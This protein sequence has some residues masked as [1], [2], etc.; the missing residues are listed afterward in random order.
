MSKRIESRFGAYSTAQEVAAGHDLQGKRAI[1]TGGASGI[2]LETVRALAQKGCEVII[3]VRNPAQ[4]DEA[5]ADIAKTSSGPKPVVELI[6]LANLTSVRKFA[7]RNGKKPLH[8]LIN[9][10]GVMACPLSYTKDDLEMQIGTNHFGHYVL[11]ILMSPALMDGAQAQGRA[12]RIVSLSSLAHRR[13]RVNF[14]DPHYRKRPYDKWESYGQSKTANVLFAVAYHQHFGDKGVSANAVMPGG[15]MTALQRYIPEEERIALGW[16]DAQGNQA[17]GF[18]TTEQ[19]ASTS[20]WAA[21]GSELEGIGGL[22]L[23]DCAQALPAEEAPKFKGVR[24]CALDVN[25]ADRLWHLSKSTTG[26]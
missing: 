15:I 19:G 7:E 8:L 14:D 23:E 6:D 21:L 26:V 25:D 10:A 11:S 18:K 4:G 16:I 12:T 17:T 3:A 20:V 5:V 13:S 22:Y 24:A 9:N 1:V 2:G